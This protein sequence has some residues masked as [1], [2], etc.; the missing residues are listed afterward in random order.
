MKQK[1]GDRLKVDIFTLDSPQALQYSFRSATNVL[2]EGELLP[3]TVALEKEKLD[4]FLA[5]RLE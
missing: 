5:D 4:E 3:L 2:F 1:Y